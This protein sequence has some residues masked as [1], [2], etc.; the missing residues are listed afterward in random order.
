M[1]TPR[2]RYILQCLTCSI[3]CVFLYLLLSSVG[4]T[5]FLYPAIRQLSQVFYHPVTVRLWDTQ[6]PGNCHKFFLLSCNLKVMG[7]PAIRQL[8]QVFY[9]LV[10]NLKVM[11]YPATRQLSQVFYY[12]IEIE[13]GL[14]VV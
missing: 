12:I 11:G 10:S 7:Y 8:S 9:H 13:A 1:R 2:L 4:T 14:G 6:Q 5:I 3:T